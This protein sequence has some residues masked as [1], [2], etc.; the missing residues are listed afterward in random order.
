MPYTS[1]ATIAD[2]DI[3]TA[4]Y[5]N[6]LSANQ[7][8]LHSL[9][10]A[11]NA[12]FNS[13]RS[14]QVLLEAAEAQWFIRHRL[15]YLH[16]K[17]ASYGGNWTYVRVYYN[18]I[19]VMGTES[20]ATSFSDSVDL[21]DITSYPNYDGAW[22]TA[23]AY[24]DDV[25]GDGGGSGNSDDG[26]IVLNDGA[27]YRCILAHTSG[28]TDDEPGTGATW[29]TYWEVVT[30]PTV[31]NIYDIYAEVLFGSGTEVGVE[32]LFETDAASL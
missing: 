4:S 19:K 15:D 23:T 1:I 24:E 2:N 12:P 17:V 26:S 8:F 27:Y 6:A 3:L 16:A 14:T 5:L 21:T 32:Y 31:G 25:N 7:E 22:T 10:N 18:G 28:D 11:A 29:E 30:P 9:G 20:G 13:H